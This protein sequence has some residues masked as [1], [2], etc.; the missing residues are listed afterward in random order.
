MALKS[1][2]TKGEFVQI[3]LQLSLI[4]WNFI[5]QSVSIDICRKFRIVVDFNLN[6]IKYVKQQTTFIQ[7]PKQRERHFSIRDIY[8]I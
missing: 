3:N 1:V 4:N 6:N 5:I 7:Y 8:L 2:V